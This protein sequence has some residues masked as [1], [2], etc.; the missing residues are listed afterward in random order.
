MKLENQSKV[1]PVALCL[2]GPTASGK[3]AC[4]M[5]LADKVDAQ[6]I[7]VDS[8]QVY[9]NLNIGAGKPSAKE[10]AQYPHDLIDIAYPHEPYS[11]YE[12]QQDALAAVHRA[13]EKSKLPILVGGTMLYFKALLEGFA[14]LPKACPETRQKIEEQAQAHGWA[15]VHQTLALVDRTTADRLEPN[16]AQRIS[17]ALEVYY[18]SGI[19]L[20]KLIQSQVMPE[21]PFRPICVGVAPEN[22]Q[23]KRL[24][25]DIEAR[26]AKMLDDGLVDEVRDLMQD[27]HFNRGLPAYK[28]VGYRQAIMHLDGVINSKELYDKGCAATRQLAKR[29]ITWLR[30]WHALTLM[31]CYD[32]QLV[33]K[34]LKVI[35]DQRFAKK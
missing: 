11:A 26:F 19:P 1:K 10:L 33:S 7:S 15:A 14:H 3:T 16:D 20:S 28:S 22:D 9:K 23:R 13:T 27:K 6:I 34:I 31:D 2:L 18:T 12:F 35:D 4:A 8:A 30:G 5:A 21:L 29:Q 32:T 24:H 25:R 17:R